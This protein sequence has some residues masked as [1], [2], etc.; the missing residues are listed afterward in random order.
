[1]SPALKAAD[2]TLLQRR[3]P[4]QLE[5]YSAPALDKGLDI[6]ELLAEEPDG[7]PQ[8]EIARRL[9]RTV[10]EIFRMLATL[11][12]RGYVAQAAGA[13]R[14]LLTLRMFAVSHQHP[15]TRLLIRAALPRMQQVARQLGQSCHLGVFHEG[16]ILIVA[17]TDA[18]GSHSYNVRM[19]AQ[20]PVF[21]AS[22][23]MILLAFQSPAT[24]AHM[25]QECP[26]Y[27]P[28]GL[29]TL[30][31]KLAR[32]RRKGIEE[33][34]SYQVKGIFN[35]SCPILDFTGA[36]IAAMTVPFVSRIGATAAER[37][38]ARQALIRA[39]EDVSRAI[40]GAEQP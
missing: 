38:D 2:T 6:L 12:H 7:L 36:A 33:I 37:T 20:V 26:D 21:Q 17:Q 24:R 22:S 19:G 8:Q 13:D 25:L 11:E 35:L 23:G 10:S 31:R 32:I 40:G 9:G 39:A 4:R 1:M 27:D 29:D 18:P 28:K 34:P 30:E 16:R 3:S 15:P 5:K 14:Y